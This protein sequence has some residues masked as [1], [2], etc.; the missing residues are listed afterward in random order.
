MQPTRPRITAR[1][2]YSLSDM[3]RAL[4]ALVAGFACLLATGARSAEPAEIREFLEVTGFDVALASI[5]L[6]VD[7]APAMLGIN[8]A[9]FG[10]DWQR[11]VADLFTEER[12]HGL[13]TRMLAPTL[14]DDMRAHAEAFYGSELG[15]RLIAV[16][17]AAHMATDDDIKATEG[18][19]LFDTATDRRRALL[20]RMAMGVDAAGVAVDAVN[21]IQVRFLMAASAA[22]LL[23]GELN[24]A[25][26]RAQLDMG[27]EAMA[28][29]MRQSG[30][31]SAAYTYGDF[32]D[33]DLE[34]YV[35]ALETPLMARVYELLNAVQYEVM[36]DRFERLAARLG[37]LRQGQEL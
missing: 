20:E 1:C 8:E 9:E 25:R 29:S 6:S 35:E 16:E 2:D 17:N 22:G 34:N 37:D 13:A 30:I 24:E 4:L 15:Q 12:L 5:A 10:R 23:D 11:G 19:R 32:S 27:R 18:A 28:A 3:R 7:D 26:L 31:H 33:D 36:A 14:S 21:D